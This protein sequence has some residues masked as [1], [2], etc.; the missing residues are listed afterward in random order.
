MQRSA[1]DSGR[2]HVIVIV[3][4]RRTTQHAN[5]LFLVQ[6]L[7]QTAMN[8]PRESL[9]TLFDPLYSGEPTTPPPC[10]DIPSPDLGS[11]KENAAPVSDN[12]ITLT[13]FLNRIYTWP[14]AQAQLPRSLPKGRL[15]DLGNPNASDDNSDSNDDDEDGQSEHVLVVKRKHES[16]PTTT[17][18][19]DTQGSPPR[20]PLA[21]I[22]L[23]DSRRSSPIA[24][25]AA[26]PAVGTLSSSSFFG[27]PSPFRP[28]PAPSASP[29]ASVINAINGT[30]SPSPPLTPS[31]PRI[32]V[33]P[34][35]PSSPSPTRRPLRPGAMLYA[36]PDPDP[37]RTSVDLQESMSVHFDDSSFDLLKDKI[38]LPEN[39]SLDH[40]D[41]DMGT[42]AVKL[43]NKGQHEEITTTLS[44]NADSESEPDFGDMVEERLRDLNI[45]EDSAQVVKNKDTDG[46]RDSICS[47]PPTRFSS[48]DTA[49]RYSTSYVQFYPSDL[50]PPHSPTG[51]SASV[52]A[53]KEQN[54]S[55]CRAYH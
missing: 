9:L 3:V 44:A 22:A 34:A 15:I 33:T 46:D 43:P 42:P 14:K 39:D 20:R 30:T 32:A 24:A 40:L 55:S 10:R 7:A 8:R 41:M 17:E 37:R 16:L 52:P 35:E 54:A 53:P 36:S 25:K 31:G 28:T 21:D 19:K 26:S 50:P 13:K 38:S 12:S 11:D 2:D 23:G 27:P 47:T 51:A 29:L 45:A 18:R 6:A 4:E 5:T 1:T 49:S 48:C